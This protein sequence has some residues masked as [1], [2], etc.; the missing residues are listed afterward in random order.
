MRHAK[1]Q[2]SMPQTQEKKLAKETPL[3]GSRCWE[4]QRLQ[5]RQI[6]SKNKRKTC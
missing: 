4:C 1:K 5:S 3:R 6:W 2:E